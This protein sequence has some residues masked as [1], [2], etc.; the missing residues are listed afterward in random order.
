[1]CLERDPEEEE[2]KALFLKCLTESSEN[3]FKRTSYESAHAENSGAV[4]SGAA[5]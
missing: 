3:Y 2:V 1:M 4:K 5:L